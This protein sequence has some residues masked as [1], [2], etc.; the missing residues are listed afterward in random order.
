[1][2]ICINSVYTPYILHV[3]IVQIVPPNLH[4]FGFANNNHSD[5]VSIQLH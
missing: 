3:Q 5:L 2:Y 4:R 1:M